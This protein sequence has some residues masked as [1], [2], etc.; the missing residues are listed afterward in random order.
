MT[1]D[2]KPSEFM[3]LKSKEYKNL[4][5]L[6][7]DLLA[8]GEK[9]P[10]IIRALSERMGVV[11]GFPEA[12]SSK[13]SKIIYAQ[14]SDASFAT[15]FIDVSS[16]GFRKS[17]TIFANSD[18]EDAQSSK[19]LFLSTIDV[20]RYNDLTA[21]DPHISLPI[22]RLLLALMSVYRRNFH[23]S[24]W[25]KYDKK[26]IFYLAGLQDLPV[27]EVEELTQ[28]LHQEY[29]LDM[30]VVGSNSPVPCFKIDWLFKQPQPGSHVNLFL[31]YG[32]FSPETITAITCGTVTPKK[33]N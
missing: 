21:A 26:F 20:E 1:Q 13:V 16:E 14:F 4:Y 3:N 28:Y 24:G 25:V 9:P 6:Y 19:K 17:Y 10:L 11:Y 22:K 15:H 5:Y 7:L 23:H 8:A 18:E 2:Y 31:D 32:E 12:V 29:G 33:I 27:K 30:Q